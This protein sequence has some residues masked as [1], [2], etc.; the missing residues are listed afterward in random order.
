MKKKF[1]LF[2]ALV[3]S[4]LLLMGC[5]KVTN[6]SSQEA[7]TQV[8]GHASGNYSENKNGATSFSY[9]DNSSIIPENMSFSQQKTGYIK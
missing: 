4:L 5:G 7:T 3:L 1:K 8:A 6:N 2:I 9:S